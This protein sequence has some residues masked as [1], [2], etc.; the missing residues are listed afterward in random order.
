EQYQNILLEIA[1]M[2]LS[3]ID[4]RRKAYHLPKLE[5]LHMRNTELLNLF[6]DRR[7]GFLSKRNL[8]KNE[9]KLDSIADYISMPAMPYYLWGITNIIEINSTDETDAIRK[10][11]KN[12]KNVINFFPIM[13]P[14]KVSRDGKTTIFEAERPLKDY[15]R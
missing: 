13:I 9:S 4:I 1:N 6:Y 11:M 15:L 14:E 10:C 3:Y 12:H 8:T 2:Y 7:A 5:I